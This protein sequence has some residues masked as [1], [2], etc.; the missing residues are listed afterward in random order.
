MSYKEP[1]I[2][3]ANIGGHEVLK[4]WLNRQIKIINNKDFIVDEA[5]EREAH[6]GLKKAISILTAKRYTED[7]KIVL[8]ER[9]FEEI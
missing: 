1:K 2:T 5:I 4:E 6:G 8:T 3:L 9:N 7:D